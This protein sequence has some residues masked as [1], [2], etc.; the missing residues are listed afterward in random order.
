LDLDIAI[1][2]D[3]VA[4]DPEKRGSDGNALDRHTRRVGGVI[5]VPVQPQL[6]AKAL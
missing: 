3:A 4:D 6:S 5:G 2:I 1:R